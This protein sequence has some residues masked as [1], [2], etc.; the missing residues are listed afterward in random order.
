MPHLRELVKL[1]EDKPFAVVG[2]NCYDPEEDYRK[3]LEEHGVSWI[4]GY[5]GE[6]ENPVANLY[7][8]Q[9]FPTYYLIDAEGKIVMTGH[10]GEQFDDKIVEL[11]AEAEKARA[12]EE[13]G[14]GL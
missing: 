1:H 7:Q 5:V 12:D 8:V 4:S 9:G 6:G 14:K 2:I 3:G 11:I 10:S 13:A